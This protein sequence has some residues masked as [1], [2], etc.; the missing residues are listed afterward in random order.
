MAAPQSIPAV[1]ERRAGETP[2][3]VGVASDDETLTYRQL[4]DTAER[5]ARSLIAAGVEP[6]D[7]VG[8]WAPN[9]VRWVPAGLGIYMAG[10]T[11]VPLNTR[12]KSAEAAYVVRASGAKVVLAVSD[13]L[14]H[15][16]AATAR[17][18]TDVPSLQR[19]V[20][21]AGDQRWSSW[22][23]EGDDVPADAVLSRV[24][25]L[26]AAS[27]SD[28]IFTSGTTG[29]PKGAVLTHGAS[30]RTYEIWSDCVGL[31]PEDRSL[32]VWP[33][34]HTAGL[35]S[36]ILG[37]LLKGAE[38]HPIAVFDVDAVMSY[39]ARHRITM[40]PGTPTVFQ[41]ILDHPRFAEFDLSSLR[42]SVT[43]AAVVPV[44]V[45]RRMREDLCFQ[46]VVTGYGLTETTGTV[47]MCRH[48]DPAEI[49]A[50]TV[51]RP[52][53]G[54][55]LKIV[56]EDGAKLGPEQAGEILVRGFNVMKEYFHDPEATRQAVDEEGWL[57]T[58]DIGFVGGDGNLRVTDRKKDMYICGGFNV[59]PAEVE[60]LIL[61]HPSVAQ[62]AVIGIADARM[63]EV[64]EAVVV[65]RHGADWDDEQFV[66]WC[67]A[68]MA[69][70]KVPRQVR[71]VD[72]LPLNPSGK[73]MK[74]KLREEAAASSP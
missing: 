45:V 26:D 68:N 44:E 28:I 73:V 61:R 40:L 43:G 17:A 37:G 32:V 9:S 21:F 53:P 52:L 14:D 24:R 51:G 36:G 39:V 29:A 19:V 31:G 8:M 6:G 5:V 65:V 47:S 7:R 13:F 71:V 67:R 16:L 11:L 22:L 20:D 33:F 12:F 10:A 38:I 72:M 41:S 18:W 1:L 60:G 49:V 64:G 70:Y 25:A 2:D 56:D 50:T 54:V 42:L 66:E 58:G 23:A 48:D 46:T 59:Y 35:K 3:R 4:Q 34:F 57:R 69:N 63:G 30:V 74:F 15:D 55:E 62:V 27:V